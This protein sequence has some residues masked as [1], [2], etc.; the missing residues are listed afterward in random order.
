MKVFIALQ[1]HFT[2]SFK[3]HEDTETPCHLAKLGLSSYNQNTYNTQTFTFLYIANLNCFMKRILKTKLRLCYTRGNIFLQLAKQRH[4]LVLFFEVKL[5]SERT[6]GSVFIT[7]INFKTLILMSLMLNNPCFLVSFVLSIVNFCVPKIK[8]YIFYTYY[9]P[10][11][12]VD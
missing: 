10:T 4:F 7:H 6:A 12:L 2:K 3:R 9:I 8:D 5:T 11:F 1:I